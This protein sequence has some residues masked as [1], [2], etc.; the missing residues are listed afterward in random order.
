MPWLSG[1]S[2]FHFALGVHWKGGSRRGE[3]RRG[4][5]GYP[6]FTVFIVRTCYYGARS[7][8]FRTA[9]ALFGNGKGEQYYG[10]PHL[11][12]MFCSP[13]PDV[14]ACLLRAH[15][16]DAK[17]RLQGPEELLFRSRRSEAYGI[18][19]ESGLVSS[20]CKRDRLWRGR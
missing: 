17:P 7:V 5:A 9:K 3:A 16:G 20:P 14:P 13:M 19:F 4:V 12:Y 10:D 8:P 18:K 2:P 6:R 15:D 11:P 1:S